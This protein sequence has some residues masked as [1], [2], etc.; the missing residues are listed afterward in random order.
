MTVKPDGAVVGGGG[1]SVVSEGG[2]PGGD[3][4]PRPPFDWMGVVGTGQSLSVGAQGTPVTLTMQPYHNMKLALGGTMVPPYTADAPG[5]MMVPLVEP[6]R[7]FAPAYPGAYPTNIYGE[8]PHTAMADQVSAL[9]AQKGQG[10]YQTVHTVVGESGMAITIID[11]AATQTGNMGHAYP[12]TLFEAQAIKRLATMAGKTYGV[13]AI[14]LTHG[15]SDA[16][17]TNYERDI[18]QLWSDYNTDLKGITGQTQSIPLLLSQQQTSPGAK[19]SSVSMIEMWHMGVTYPGDLICV[20]PK[21]QYQ[22]AEGL[23]LTAHEY[24]RLGEKY[25]EVYYEKVVLGHNWQPLQPKTVAK[26]GKV[27]TVDFNVPVGALNWDENITAPHQT[28]NTEWAKGRGFEVTSSAG[29]AAI[30]SVAIDGTKVVITLTADVQATGW[31]VAY[32]STQDDDGT[33]GGPTT[34]R[35]GQLRDTDP[36]VGLDAETISCNVTMGSAAITP[37]TANGFKLHGARDMAEGAGLAAETIVLTKMSDSAMTLS[38]P[39]TGA[40]GT[41]DLKLRS[42]Q[43]NYCVS[44]ELPIN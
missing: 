3:V 14:V 44:F 11:K 13:G 10:E 5:L 34:G 26:A 24:D 9:F 17:N 15:E 1:A 41:V 22:Y 12:A 38:N 2:S 42:D 6:I 29:R 31:K 33:I 7:P 18:H 4:P 23:H 25:G 40:T 30:D 19:G 35:R 28:A 39:W 32:A 20:G 8:T 16:G 21:Y 36:L 37:K 43:R 27:I